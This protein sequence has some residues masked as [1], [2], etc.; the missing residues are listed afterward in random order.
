MFNAAV[1]AH[2][3][4]IAYGCERKKLREMR[5]LIDHI[6]HD[7]FNYISLKYVSTAEYRASQ[8]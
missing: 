6:N 7:G 5:M 4:K 2:A 1:S 3:V 8:L